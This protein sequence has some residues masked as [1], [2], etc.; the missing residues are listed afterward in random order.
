M[1]SASHPCEE[2]PD[3]FPLRSKAN[4]ARYSPN[5]R[6]TAGELDAAQKVVFAANVSF[7]K[8]GI[9][10]DIHVFQAAAFAKLKRM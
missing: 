6:G 5:I 2:N 7:L 8:Y 9:A 4:G 1:H 10:D 3:D